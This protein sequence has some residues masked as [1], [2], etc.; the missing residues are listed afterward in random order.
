MVNVYT[1]K[2]RIKEIRKGM[3][4]SQGEFARKLSDVTLGVNILEAT[5][6]KWEL[7]TEKPLPSAIEALAFLSKRSVKWLQSAVEDNDN[8]EESTDD[9]SIGN[10]NYQESDDKDSSDIGQQ[11]SNVIQFPDNEEPG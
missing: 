1:V 5:V 2:E 4:L 8:I 3:G 11:K 6:K 9:G 10:T 7:G